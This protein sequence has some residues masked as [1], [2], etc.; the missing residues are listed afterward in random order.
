MA[1]YKYKY[2]IYGEAEIGGCYVEI[3]EIVWADGP[4]Q[5]FLFLS[6]RIRGKGIEEGFEQTVFLGHCDIDRI[7]VSTPVLSK[8]VG[9]KQLEIFNIHNAP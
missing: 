2:K 1:K 5:A 6:K 9:Q 8:H 7:K 3:N 4:N